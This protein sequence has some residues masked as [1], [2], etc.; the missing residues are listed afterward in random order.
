MNPYLKYPLYLLVVAGLGF[1]AWHW[2][3]EWLPLVDSR[4][5]ESPNEDHDEDIH[6]A[7]ASQDSPD[8]LELSPQ[9]Q[10]NLGLQVRPVVV[11]DYWKKIQIPGTIEDRPGVTDQGIMSPL[12]GV[13]TRVHAFAGDIVRPGQKLFSIRLVS[14]YL[15]ELQGKLF[16]ASNE[17]KLLEIEVNRVKGLASAGSIP[18]K[19]LIELEQEISRQQTLINANRQEL[20]SRGLTGEQV[21]QIQQGS[22]LNEIE[23][24]VPELETQPD[25]SELLAGQDVPVLE[26]Q[27]LKAALGEQVQPG[28]PLATLAN[29][30]SLYIKGHAFKNEAALLANAAEK[31]YSI[32]VQFTEDHAEQWPPLDQSFHIRHLANTTDPDSRTF[33]F[34]I[35][36]TNQSRTYE[37]QGNTVVFWRFRPGQRV[38]LFVPVEKVENVIVLPA[39]GVAFEGPEAFVFQQNGKLFNRIPVQVLHQDRQNVVIANDGSLPFGFFLAQNSAASLNRVLKA[40]ASSGAPVGVH[41]HADGT[42]HAAH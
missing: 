26:V 19:R 41:V 29:H 20:L 22:F 36:L 6:K 3:S 18:G 39:E 42:V 11:S 31:Q 30:T 27:E 34:F 28:Q 23:I 15:Q 33:D 38:N 4:F 13:V 32:E 25:S 14:A 12:E 9:A 17:I 7:P 1:G 8:M 5:A 40:Q 37:K 2:K 16:K 24:R 10:K 21:N 35:P